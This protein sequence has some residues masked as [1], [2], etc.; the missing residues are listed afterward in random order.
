LCRFSLRPTTPAVLYPHASSSA[1]FGADARPRSIVSGASSGL[2]QRFTGERRAMVFVW[3][4]QTGPRS[5]GR[6]VG[7]EQLRQCVGQSVLDRQRLLRILMNRS[8]E[9][10]VTPDDDSDDRA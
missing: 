6:K 1:F 7:A 10:R 8:Q 9:N 5:F 4:A 3:H 2:L